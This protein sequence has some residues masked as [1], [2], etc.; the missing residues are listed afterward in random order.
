ME[1]YEIMRIAAFI[2]QYQEGTG[3]GVNV[4]FRDGSAVWHQLGLRSFINKLAKVFTLNLQESR[5]RFG[6][7]IGRQNLIPLVL[8]PFLLYVPLKTRKPMIAGDPTYG[9]FRLRSLLEVAADPKPCTL[10][11]EGGSKLTITQS[12]RA[13]CSHLRAARKLETY[14]IEHLIQ[15]MDEGIM[16][17]YMQEATTNAILDRKPRDTNMNEP[18]DNSADIH[19]IREKT[20]DCFWQYLYEV[21][22]SEPFDKCLCRQCRKNVT[23]LVQTHLPPALPAGS[24]VEKLLHNKNKL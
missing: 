18:L 8:S 7:I 1:T 3:Q 20:A 5:R 2:P 9:Y 10:L 16:V 11:L 17:E 22:Q 19:R 24:N 13:V 23:A 15:L 6:P 4:F 14:L 21:L 12:Y